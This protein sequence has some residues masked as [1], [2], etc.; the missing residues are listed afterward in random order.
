MRSRSY[1]TNHTR[2]PEPQTF[3]N[4]L[5][6]YENPNTPERF[7]IT[8]N[9]SESETRKL[10]KNDEILVLN[11]TMLNSF[12]T[13]LKIYL[14][15]PGQLTRNNHRHDYDAILSSNLTSVNSPSKV[16]L[17]IVYVSVSRLRKDAPNKCLN[18]VVDEDRLRRNKIRGKVC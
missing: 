11:K 3:R 18:S 12:H 8:R 7:C 6:F 17:K 5:Q 4:N 2:I 16:S 1:R 10:V 13:W 9:N 14:H 15:H